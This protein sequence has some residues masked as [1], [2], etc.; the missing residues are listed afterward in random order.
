MKKF[1][2]NFPPPPPPEL[3]TSAGVQQYSP[4]RA[5]SP[6]SDEDDALGNIPPPPLPPPPSTASLPPRKVLGS[7]QAKRR[8]QAFAKAKYTNSPKGKSSLTFTDEEENSVYSVVTSKIEKKKYPLVKE[9]TPVMASIMKEETQSREIVK[10]NM[11]K[12]NKNRTDVDLRDILNSRKIKDDEEKDGFTRKSRSRE[13]KRHSDKTGKRSPKTSKERDL[14]EEES[15]SPSPRQDS[16]SNRRRAKKSSKDRIDNSVDEVKRRRISGG[17]ESKDT[18]KERMKT[19]DDF[20]MKRLGTLD[21]QKSPEREDALRKKETKRNMP[22]LREELMKEKLARKDIDLWELKHGGREEENNDIPTKKN[23]EVLIKANVDEDYQEVKKVSR[24]ISNL[25]SNKKGLFLKFPSKYMKYTVSGVCYSYNLAMSAELYKGEKRSAQ[26]RK[27]I[28]SMM[29]ELENE[30]KRK[31]SMSGEK[32]DKNENNK[33]ETKK[34]RKRKKIQKNSEIAMKKKKKNIQSKK[35]DE[36]DIKDK[37]S[38]CESSPEL[39]QNKIE[40]QNVTLS[41]AGISKLFSMAGY[42]DNE[43]EPKKK[44]MPG[45]S[46]E[47]G[48]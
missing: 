25:V 39:K 37:I 30:T 15:D 40:A 9:A 1:N 42:A 23:G 45:K 24:D 4:S 43:I 18:S 22:D 46:K 28:D 10:K 33:A 5:T 44:T 35:V 20:G 17:T 19:K 8:L 34:G 7:D 26:L 3:P 29:Y 6:N 11:E 21:Q 12:I 47:A 16:P 13:R 48:K 38:S 41:A 14:R 2:L 32:I 31:R 36:D 27:S